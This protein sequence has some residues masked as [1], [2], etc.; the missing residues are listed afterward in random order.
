MLGSL[1]NLFGSVL[2]YIAM[3]ATL[4]PNHLTPFWQLL[5]SKTPIFPVLGTGKHHCR[6]NFR[7][8][9]H[10]ISLSV[11]VFLSVYCKSHLATRCLPVQEVRSSR[12]GSEGPPALG[13]GGPGSWWLLP[14]LGRF[15]TTKFLLFSLKPR[16]ARRLKGARDP[17]VQR[18]R[19]QNVLSPT[20]EPH[21]RG[22]VGYETPRRISD[23]RGTE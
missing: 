11:P 21:P 14:K 1:C 23:G 16:V 13:D 20:V 22:L 7:G 4:I 15:I 5:T 3:G 10:F 18:E 6:N 19:P 12:L 9:K 17:R 8:K 2:I